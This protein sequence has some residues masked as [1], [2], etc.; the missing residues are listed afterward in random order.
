M[1]RYLKLV[2]GFN[3]PIW[4]I[5]SSNWIISPSRVE[6]KKCLKPPPSKRYPEH[7]KLMVQKSGVANQLIRQ[8]SYC[9]QGI[10]YIPRCCTISSINS[11]SRIPML[12]LQPDRFLQVVHA[13]AT[14]VYPGRTTWPR[15]G[16][17]SC[18]ED[19]HCALQLEDQHQ[20]HQEQQ[21]HQQD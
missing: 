12:K 17:V 8:I 14:T 7:T 11:I 16:G 13:G 21:E 2:G 5:C 15:G 6:N 4:K 20:Q 18:K 9:L 1:G 10:L 19:K 3:Q